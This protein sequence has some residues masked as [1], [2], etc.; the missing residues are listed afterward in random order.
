M[1]MRARHFLPLAPPMSMMWLVIGGLAIVGSLLAV[2]YVSLA[3]FFRV[4]AR[5]LVKQAERE[6][7]P[8]CKSKKKSVSVGE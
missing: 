7:I 8:T 2:A 1:L 4:N 3:T 5:A 6:S